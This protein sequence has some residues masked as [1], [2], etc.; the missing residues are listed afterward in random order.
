MGGLRQSSIGNSI[1]PARAPAQGSAAPSVGGSEK[2]ERPP[3]GGGEFSP[4]LQQAYQQ[5]YTQGL[6][7]HSGP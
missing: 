3:A 4:R 1:S 5:L 7:Q 2:G 6:Q